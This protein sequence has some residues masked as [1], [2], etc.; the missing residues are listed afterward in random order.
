M[1]DYSAKPSEQVPSNIAGVHIWVKAPC[2]LTQRV[3]GVT[4]R[5]RIA[6][7]CIIMELEQYHTCH[8]EC[9]LVPYSSAM[10]A[11]YSMHLQI[12]KKLICKCVMINDEPVVLTD[13]WLIIYTHTLW[14]ITVSFV[15]TESLP[16]SEEG[17]SECT[18]PESCDTLFSKYKWSSYIHVGNR[19]HG[20]RQ[21]D[22]LQTI[23]WTTANH[24]AHVPRVSN[25]VIVFRCVYM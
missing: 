22:T 25:T 21:T 4:T 10:S 18:T 7:D 17:G 2:K 13:L 24:T 20:N 14:A 16:G 9:I 11:D 23:S 15:Y 19:F 5:M 3:K 1:K 6:R 12:A 8:Q